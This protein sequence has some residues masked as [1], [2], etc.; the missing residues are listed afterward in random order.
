MCLTEVD[1]IVDGS[2]GVLPIEV[3]YG[4]TVKRSSLKALIAF[5]K[6]NKLPAGMII[7]QSEQVEW[8]TPEIVQV[9]VGWL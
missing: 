4:S 8:L 6:D 3:K 9:P 5:V 7:N 1:L 2:F